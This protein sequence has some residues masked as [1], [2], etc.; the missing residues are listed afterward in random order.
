MGRVRSQGEYKTLTLDDQGKS[1]KVWSL[2]SE[3]Y[4]A[5]SPSVLGLG[6]ISARA[7]QIQ[8]LAAIFDLSGFTKF[9][10]Q[11]D[12]HLAVPEYLSRF[13]NWLFDEVK[14]GLLKEQS[15]NE[16]LLWASLPF[17]AK[18]LGDGL[19]F[20]W[21]TEKTS[22]AEI[23]NIVT[24][25]WEICDNYLH[26]FYTDIRRTVT[27][28]PEMLR[29]GIS[30]GIVFSV[31]NGEDYVGP[32]INIAARLQ[33]LSYLTF[34]VSRRGFDFEKDMPEE[35]SEKYLLKS[36]S[37]RGIGE[38]ELVWVRKEEFYLLPDDEKASFKNP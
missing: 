16:T 2:D 21:E 15:D 4:D 6:D 30:R 11:V 38:D 3:Q 28:P 26:G 10:S 12:P 31:G 32:C 14:R 18:F 27:K 24:S 36:V 9:C 29:C 19:L 8:A 22:G 37:L 5:F 23:C 20:L 35:T 25:L 33:K 34:C 7:E 17:L 13:L 1:G